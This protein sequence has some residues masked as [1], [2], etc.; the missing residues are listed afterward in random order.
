MPRSAPRTTHLIPSPAKASCRRTATNPDRQGRTR[1]QND[2]FPDAPTAPMRPGPTSEQTRPR[3]SHA[4]SRK[5]PEKASLFPTKSARRTP[6][7]RSVRLVRMSRAGD[8]PP[9]GDPDLAPPPSK[10]PSRAG[11]TGRQEQSPTLPD[12][13]F[14]PYQ[15]NPTAVFRF[16]ESRIQDPPFQEYPYER[17][18]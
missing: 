15:P 14:R 4:R 12:R 3:Q 10:T 2:T 18:S 8:E 9:T 13:C 6:A 5:S 1:S 16:H 17:M 11:R 7:E